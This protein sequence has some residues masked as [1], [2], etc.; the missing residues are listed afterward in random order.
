MLV[1]NKHLFKWILEVGGKCLTGG[2]RTGWGLGFD[3]GGVESLSSATERHL[4]GKR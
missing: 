3:A 4:R 1:Y 2:W